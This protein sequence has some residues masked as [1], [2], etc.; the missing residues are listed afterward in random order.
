MKGGG[1]NAATKAKM[2]LAKLEAEKKRETLLGT[3]IGECDTIK[4]FLTSEQAYVDNR[5]RDFSASRA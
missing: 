1:A 5:T 4:K 3:P 2:L